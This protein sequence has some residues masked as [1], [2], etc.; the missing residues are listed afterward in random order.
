MADRW[1]L[2]SAIAAVGMNTALKEVIKVGLPA[3]SLL[4]A[5]TVFIGCL[6][7]VALNWVS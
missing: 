6:T 3:I 7:V 1:A 2:L 4:V 5:E